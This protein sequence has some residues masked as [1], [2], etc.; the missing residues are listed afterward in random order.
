LVDDFTHEFDEDQWETTVTASGMRELRHLQTYYNP[1]P[2]QFVDTL[3]HAAVLAT[4]RDPPEVAFNATIYDGSPEPK[5]FHD[6]K[7]S[8]DWLNWWGAMCT[9]FVNMQSKQVWTII[10]RL[11]L[12]ANSKIIGN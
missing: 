9:K 7:I 12:P 6:V 5:I 10:P 2:L 8:H 1:N 11:S 4:F 3:Q